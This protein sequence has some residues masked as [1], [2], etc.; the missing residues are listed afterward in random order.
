MQFIKHLIETEDSLKTTETLKS[1][2]H[3]PSVRMF[4]PIIFDGAILSVQA[5]GCHQCRPR[6]TVDLGKYGAMEVALFHYSE[7][8][9][10]KRVL[11]NFK[12]LEDV[13]DVCF[14]G[15]LYGHMPVDLIEDVFQA[16]KEEYGLKED[17]K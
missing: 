6:E 1:L 8:A 16:M 17:V 5:S 10:V 7:F 11:P 13:E 9:E 2:G 4:N 14:D 15:M 12:R 3:D